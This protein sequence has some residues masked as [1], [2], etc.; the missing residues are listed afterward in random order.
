M[1]ATRFRPA[2]QIK[3]MTMADRV[4]AEHDRRV[5]A[6][7][8]F[9]IS[10]YGPIHP[11]GALRTQAVLL[12]M[13]DTARDLKAAEITDPVL[14]FTGWDGDHH[15]TADQAIELVDAGKA[16]MQQMHAAKRALKLMDPIP[17]DFADDGWWA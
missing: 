1:S 8:V 11:D 2:V 3:P 9:E 13:K 16:W 10:G 4:D 15:L 12:A 17:A 6:G 5:L 14:M 7:R